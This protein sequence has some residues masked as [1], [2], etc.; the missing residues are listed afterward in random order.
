[1][2]QPL[3]PPH[4]GIPAGGFLGY[5]LVSPLFVSGFT[6]RVKSRPVSAFVG[7]QRGG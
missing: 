4:R 3:Q 2:G 5:Y 7:G 6:G 1:M